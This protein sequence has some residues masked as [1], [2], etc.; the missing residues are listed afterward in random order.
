MNKTILNYLKWLLVIMVTVLTTGIYIWLCILIAKSID[1]LESLPLP[2]LYLLVIILSGLAAVI[3]IYTSY[4]L[5]PAHK[6]KVIWVSYLLGFITVSAIVLSSIGHSYRFFDY[7]LLLAYLS[8]AA[9]GLIFSLF[10][11]KKETNNE[12]R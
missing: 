9:G 11:S 12:T 2:L 10:L 6:R 8:P 7:L 4:R 5:A 3:W 1:K